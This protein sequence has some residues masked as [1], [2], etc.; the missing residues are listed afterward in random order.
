MCIY[1]CGGVDLLTAGSM[2]TVL[3]NTGVWQTAVYSC[4]LWW[5]DGSHYCCVFAKI[6]M[7]CYGN[8]RVD[9]S[10]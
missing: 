6:P 3:R 5:T 8:C 1:F 10:D 9:L 4:W 7:G 2:V